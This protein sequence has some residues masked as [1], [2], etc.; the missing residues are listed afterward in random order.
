MADTIIHR[1]VKVAVN[2]VKPIHHKGRVHQ[3]GNSSGLKLRIIFAKTRLGNAMS[4]AKIER[5]DNASLS[6]IL[7]L[8]TQKPK[9]PRP[10]STATDSNVEMIGV[11]SDPLC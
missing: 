9:N 2:S 6:R 1:P 4:R 10:N 7:L 8:M 5:N 11:K 3:P